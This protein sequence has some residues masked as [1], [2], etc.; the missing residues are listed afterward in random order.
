MILKTKLYTFRQ[1]LFVSALSGILISCDVKKSNTDPSSEYSRIFDYSDMNLSFFPVDLEQTG[2]GGFLILSV[3][4]DSTLSTFPLI[5]LMKTDAFGKKIWENW[6]DK[7]YCSAIPSLMLLGNSY[8]FICM[9]AVNQ[10]SRVMRIN[11]DTQEA[12]EIKA[13]SLQYPLYSMKDSH[14]DVLVL[15][16]DRLGRKSIL[17]CFNDE[18]ED[19]WTRE[20]P[21]IGDVKHQ[22]ELHLAKSGKQFPFFI[23]EVGTPSTTHYFVNCFYNYTMTMLF[24]EGAAGT[25]TG[26]LYS[27][28]ENAAVSSAV[29]IE[30]NRFALTRYYSGDN[31]VNPSVE[32]ELEDMRSITDYPDFAL[33]ELSPDAPVKCLHT[34][35][36]NKD[37]VVFASQTRANQLCL[38]FYDALNGDLKTVK[39]LNEKYPVTLAG[40]DYTRE[41]GLALLTQ[42]YVVG[43][44]PRIYLIKLSPEDL[45]Y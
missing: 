14:G 21:I 20:F 23:G 16:F 4:T 13:L 36:N 10:E 11:Q 43:R 42:T 6:L 26:T 1:I 7:A 29:S 35:I 25:Q 38:Y 34:E 27:F 39:F 9:D 22:I 3:Y 5:H 44:F 33:P 24:V 40:M 37:V 12:T 18:F 8:Y 19:I 2:D 45:V 31:F 15:N 30:N 41:K 28:Q 32:L 17:T